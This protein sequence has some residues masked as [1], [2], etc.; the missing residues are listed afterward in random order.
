M[1]SSAQVAAPQALTDEVASRNTIIAVKGMMCHNCER[2]VKEA[3]EA[4]PGVE[5]AEADFQTGLVTVHGTASEKDMKA[6]VKAAGYK[7]QKLVK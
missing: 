3:L 4:L 6:A 1:G 2:H 7:F 5:S